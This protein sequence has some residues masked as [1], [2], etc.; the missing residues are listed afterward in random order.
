MRT[1]RGKAAAWLTL[2]LLP[3]LS[4]CGAVAAVGTTV[5]SASE[6]IATAVKDTIEEPDGRPAEDDEG[7]PDHGGK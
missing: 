1:V 6:A 7:G 5:Y 4:G 2:A 3:A